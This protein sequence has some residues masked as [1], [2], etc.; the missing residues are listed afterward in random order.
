[1]RIGTLII[2]GVV[3]AG[4]SQISGIPSRSGSLSSGAPAILQSPASGR[5]LSLYSF[6]GTGSGGA[7]QA[8]LVRVSGALYGTTSSDGKGYGTVF[9]VSPL[10]KVRV[11]YSFGGYPDG[12]YPEAGLLWFKGALYGTTSAGGI[13]NGGTVFAVALSGAEHVIHSFGKTGDG[14]EPTASLVAY[15]GVLYGTTR[16]GGSRNRGTV[17]ELLPSGAEHV[18]HSFAGSPT[19]GGH[20]T[21]GLL[22][23]HG[24]FY[25]VTRAGGTTAPGGAA[26][27]IDAFGQERVLHSFGVE[28]GDGANP[29]GTL[30][31]LNGD[32]FGT[33]L[34]GG[35]VP[36]GVG[37]VFVMNTA[38]REAVIHDFG[39]GSDG[40]FP[41]AGLVALNGTLYGTTTGGGT[42]SGRCLSSYFGC[43]TLFKIS[44]F[45]T[46]RV[47]YRF[48]GDPDGAN[49]EAAL[50][51]ANGL[52][53][54]TTDWGGSADH[55][56]TIFR[57][58]P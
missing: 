4:C 47:L 28:R 3:L 5:Y 14:A 34:H 20:P 29:A 55:Y 10:G 25:G 41:T 42:N 21:A 49:P 52:L 58:F 11:L 56:G 27:K 53:Y 45:G 35:Y 16:N 9:G 13:H 23:V 18:L 40:E 44:Q 8:G 24:A 50:A 51:V 15:N 36:G 6:R 38:G 46:E 26:F 19:D 17:F 37:T 32:L 22:E 1:M 54:G 12:T 31:Y 7:P 57:L 30:V 48:T 2:C 43:G 39:K 33:T